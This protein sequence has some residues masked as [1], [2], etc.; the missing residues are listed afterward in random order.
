[1][2]RKLTEK[3]KELLSLVPKV[4]EELSTNAKLVFGNI[5][6]WYGTDFSK[7]NGYMYRSQSE[8]M[9]DCGI[10]SKTTI[11]NAVRELE[12]KGMIEVKRG[13]FGV[14]GVSTEYRICGTLYG[15]LCG[16]VTKNDFE[17]LLKK[18][19]DMSLKI[20][21]LVEENKELKKRLE[22]AENNAKCTTDTDSDSNKNIKS[23]TRYQYTMHEVGI[24]DNLITLFYQ[25]GRLWGER[26]VSGEEFFF[27]LNEEI[28]KHS[29]LS[30]EE[31]DTLRSI[32][33]DAYTGS[34]NTQ[35]KSI[36]YAD[37]PFTSFV[38]EAC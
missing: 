27:N 26:Q 21:E 4:D 20:N 5:I 9:E 32:A 3:Q 33:T 17:T 16:T 24:D 1:M 29:G 15:T 22:I 14:R 12:L 30:T 19:D 10:G 34:K 28:E 11:T 38:R 31:R 25:K 35:P 18:I 13:K 2:P 37:A 6:K 7:E 8:M 23:N 36:P